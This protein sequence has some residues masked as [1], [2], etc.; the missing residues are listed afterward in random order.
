[1]SMKK[2]R[3]LKNPDSNWDAHLKTSYTNCRGE[4]TSSWYSWANLI[5]NLPQQRRAVRLFSPGRCPNSH[6]LC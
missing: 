6:I 2:L 4:H 1:M 3:E 5:R